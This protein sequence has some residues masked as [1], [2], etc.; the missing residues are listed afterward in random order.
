MAELRRIGTNAAEVE[1]SDR[2]ILFSYDTAVAV[3]IRGAGV[4]ATYK[5][6]SRTTSG[7]VR[8]WLKYRG[9]VSRVSQEDINNLAAGGRPGEI[10]L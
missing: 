3:D 4:F 8:D 6:W 10:K 1:V 7:H 2:T 5:Y 9:H